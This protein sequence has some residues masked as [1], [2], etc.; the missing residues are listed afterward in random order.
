MK[1]K[2]ISIPKWQQPWLWPEQVKVASRRLN[3]REF[4]EKYPEYSNPDPNWTPMK[5]RNLNGDD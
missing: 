2:N 3:L 4:R 5:P 1:D